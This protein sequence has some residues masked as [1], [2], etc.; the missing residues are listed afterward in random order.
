MSQLKDDLWKTL[1]V[2]VE[3]GWEQGR[4]QNFRGNVCLQGAINIAILGKAYSGGSIPLSEVD[5]FRRRALAEV[6]SRH[7]GGNEYIIDWNDYPGRTLEEVLKL[8]SD[9][10]IAETV[11]EL[12]D[13]QKQT[14]SAS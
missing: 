10:A 14:E 4:N 6:I 8:V 11:K 9:A 3:Y 12:K 5:R 13:A 2:L 1:Q 7:F